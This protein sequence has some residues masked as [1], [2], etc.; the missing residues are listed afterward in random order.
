MSNPLLSNKIR[1]QFGLLAWIWAVLVLLQSTS[2]GDVNERQKKIGDLSGGITPRQ[3]A[4]RADVRQAIDPRRFDARLL[5]A[6]IF[7]RTNM[8]RSAH[9]LKTLTY[10]ARVACAAQSHAE[11]MARRHYLSHGTLR[12]GK[13]LA[14]YER[15]RN[16]GLRPHFSAENIAYKFLLHYQ[17]GRPVFMREENGETVYSYER[18]GKPLERHTYIGFARD[19]VQQWMDSPRHRENLLSKEATQLGVGCALSA[20]QNGLHRIFCDQDFFAPFPPAA[21]RSGD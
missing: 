5:S 9:H 19:V 2:V 3:F 1:L 16:A 7:H 13:I 21:L 14:P 6:A 4:R 12:E 11:I 18:G 17:S 15:L 10:N 20:A 8:V